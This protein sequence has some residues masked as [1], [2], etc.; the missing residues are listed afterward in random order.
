MRRSSVK[1][2]LAGVTVR[3]FDARRPARVASESFAASF[4]Q[5]GECEEARASSMAR[6]TRS[7]P[8]PVV[9]EYATSSPPAPTPPAAAASRTLRA[10]ARF[11]CDSFW[12]SLSDLVATVR[13]GL[14]LE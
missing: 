9:A 7:R 11:L 10:R 13:K 4:V 3:L 2:P 12:E 5:E 14:P 1:S 6:Q 8:R